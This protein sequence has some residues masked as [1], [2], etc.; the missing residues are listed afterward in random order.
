[1]S[2]TSAIKALEPK[3]DYIASLS[4]YEL[5]L[6]G[7]D[8]LVWK[9]TG[10][11]PKDSELAKVE[12]EIIKNLNLT[13]PS[14]SMRI[15]ETMVMDEIVRRFCIEIAPYEPESEIKTCSLQVNQDIWYIN[16]DDPVPEH[17]IVEFINLCKDGSLDSFSVA[18]DNGDFDEFHGSVYLK[19][20]FDTKEDA[21]LRYRTWHTYTEC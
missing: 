5:A 14:S 12:K 10:L 21:E 7:Q 16:N 20:F 6:L 1:M 3:N 17:G 9:H 18:F 4:S 11:L 8:I 19:N 2:I 15:T 13:D